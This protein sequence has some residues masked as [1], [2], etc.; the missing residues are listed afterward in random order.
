MLEQG[1]LILTALSVAFWVWACFFRGGFWRADQRLDDTPTDLQHWPGI[2][3]VIPA[4]NEAETIGQTVASLLAQDYPGDVSVIVVDDGS[5]DGT[6]AAAGTSERLSVIRGQALEAGWTGKLW[7]MKQGLQEADRTHPNAPFVLLTDADIVHDPASLRRLAAKAEQ[8]GLDLVSLMALLRCENFWERL[9]V[10]AFIFF[11]QKLYPFPWVNDP[12][13]P[14]AA[15]AGGCVLVRRR[16]LLDA[17]GVD[18]IRDRLIDDC[19]LAAN[20][21][22]RGPIWLGLT[23]KV[24]S[25]RRYDSLAEIWRM[26]ARTAFEQLGNSPLLLIGAVLGMGVAYLVPPL[27][28][29][30]IWGGGWMVM[31]VGLTTWLGLA[32]VAYA[33]TLRLY[34]LSFGWILAL[35]LAALLFTLMT[36][37][38]AIRHWQGR[39]STWKGRSY[40][41]TSTPNG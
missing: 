32:G 13:R 20:I 33:P 21:K 38:S 22:K 23:E 1:G 24:R 31:A 27:A 26:V 9:L 11:F 29:V 39:G 25:L 16:A 34:G 35:P 19:A 4:R 40:R 36:F 12:S 3:C 15:A 41:A 6:A 17:G 14:A 18:A 37:S 10:P 7:A 8:D 28:S 5:D 2:V 30:G